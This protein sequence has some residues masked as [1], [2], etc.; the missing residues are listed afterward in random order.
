[1][2]AKFNIGNKVRCSRFGSTMDFDFEG[3]VTHKADAGDEWEYKVTN[4]PEL[5]GGVLILIWESEMEKL[6]PKPALISGD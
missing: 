2:K 1:M 5:F 6:S 4:A 3:E